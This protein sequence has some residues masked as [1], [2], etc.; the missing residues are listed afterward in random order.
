MRLPSPQRTKAPSWHCSRPSDSSARLSIAA[1]RESDGQVVHARMPYT[2]RHKKIAA[3]AMLSALIDEHLRAADRRRQSPLRIPRHAAGAGMSAAHG[4]A[5]LQ[6]QRLRVAR[7]LQIAAAHAL[8]LR[9][10]QFAQAFPVDRAG[11]AAAV[12]LLVVQQRAHLEDAGRRLDAPSRRVGRARAR[13]GPAC[14]RRSKRSSSGA[15]HAQRAVGACAASRRPTAPCRRGAACGRPSAR[16]RRRGSCRSSPSPTA[17][18][19]R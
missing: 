15:E 3:N 6:P 14:A 12:E 10:E 7:H 17:S 4:A 16:R 2:A 18:G 1:G 11:R 5:P 13:A 8:A 9:V 19:C